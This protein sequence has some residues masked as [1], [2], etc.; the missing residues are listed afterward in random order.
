MSMH[1]ETFSMEGNG[2][3]ISSR[4]QTQDDI[5]KRKRFNGELLK[6]VD[7]DVM[8]TLVSHIPVNHL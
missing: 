7:L 4:D 6:L 2:M 5:A 8:D 3:N 1:L